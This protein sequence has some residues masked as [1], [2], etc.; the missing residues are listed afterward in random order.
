[1]K[2]LFKKYEEI[3]IYLI[4]GVL[5]TIVSWGACFVA[6]LFLDSTNDLQNFIINTIGWVAG[7][8]FAYP[9]N[10]IWVFKSTN[11]NILK[12]FFGFAAS[13]LSTWI[14]DIVIMWG[15]VNKWPVFRPL[16]VSFCEKFSITSISE[17]VDTLHYWFVKI[18]ISAVLVTILNYVFSK[19]LIF[20]KKKNKDNDEVKEIKEEK[21]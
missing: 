16:F 3:I 2:K 14:L 8:L 10:R 17:P 12:E 20:G 19:V 9:L 18:F 4:V 15:L 21:K 7:V 6:K 11:K 5:T 13:R 1:M